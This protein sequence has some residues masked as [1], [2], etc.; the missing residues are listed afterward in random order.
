MTYK[1]L[2][3]WKFDYNK[4]KKEHDEYQ[5]SI[6]KTRWRKCKKENKRKREKDD[7][8]ALPAIDTKETKNNYFIGDTGASCHMTHSDDGLFN[9]KEIKEP[10][11]VGNGQTMTATKLGTNDYC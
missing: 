3:K 2:V 4:K 7:D 5:K 1:E 6:R 10:I 8:V 9:V 11:T